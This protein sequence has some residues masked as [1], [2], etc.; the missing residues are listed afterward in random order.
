MRR[1]LV[2][3]GL[4]MTSIVVIAFLIP[5]GL[6]ARSLAQERALAAARQDAQSVAVFA[7]GAAAD[8]VRL[9]AAV[10]AVNGGDRSTTVFLPD[11]TTVGPP[12]EVSRA[13]ELAALGRAVTARADGGIDVVVPVGGSGGIAVVRTFVP[14]PILMDGVVRAWLL[15][16][17]VGAALL[18]VTAVAGDRIAARLARSVLDLSAAAERLGAGDLTARVEPSGPAEVVTV[19][20]VLNTLGAQVE[21]QLAAE[22]EM[23]ADL[24]HRLRTPVTALRLDVEDLADPQERDRLTADVERLIGAVDAIVRAARAP[25][26]AAAR[27][28]DAAAVVRERA[29][30][31]GVLALAQ[32]RDLRVEV[33]DGT[34]PV[35]LAAD[36]LGAALDALVDNVFSHTP[37]GTGFA[38]VVRPVGS[39]PEGP[40]T[41]AVVVED[42]GAG[43]PTSD[44]TARGKSGAGSTGLGLAVARRTAE[45]AGGRLLVGTGPTGGARVA[46]EVPLRPARATGP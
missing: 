18:V 38:L 19:G 39:G 27:G 9:E 12:A 26:D 29:R 13:V 7:G 25:R 24:S 32:G 41:V 15:L 1:L 16:A 3:Y 20:R 33:A 5:L 37:E 2:R 6:F 44:V 22:R 34:W 35:P 17:G 10:L 21:G 8:P 23:V 43:L 45:D 46:L 40:G 31:W 14:D 42:D 28:C 4:A 11:G 30:F 36:E